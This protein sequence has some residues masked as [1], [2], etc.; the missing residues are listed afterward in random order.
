LTSHLIFASWK[1]CLN[2]N[3]HQFNHYQQNKQSP[4]LNWT[5]WTQKRPRHMTLEIQILAWVRQNNLAVLNRLMRSQPSPF[6][7]WISSCNAYIFSFD[8]LCIILVHVYSLQGCYTVITPR[9]LCNNDKM[10]YR[11]ILSTSLRSTCSYSYYL[12]FI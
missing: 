7:T 2:R 11:S 10:D 3:G 5:Y 1:W 9:W 6:D 12:M 4:L 8:M